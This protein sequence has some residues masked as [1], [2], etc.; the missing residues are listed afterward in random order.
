MKDELNALL[1][2]ART[3]ALVIQELPDETLVYDE[4]RHKAHCLNRTAAL[5]W[6]QCDGRTTVAQMGDRLGEG[7]Q[8]PAGNELVMIALRQLEKAKLLATPVAHLPAEVTALSRRQVM[9]TIGLVAAVAL[10]LVT[11]ILAPTPAQAG[12]L[13][14][15][16][17]SCTTGAECDSGVCAVEEC[18]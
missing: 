13:K 4:E 1:P 8:I 11:S 18:L 3:N 9:K 10:P 17:G 2:L 12:S 5:V 16:G 14:G 15:S 7:V 6:K